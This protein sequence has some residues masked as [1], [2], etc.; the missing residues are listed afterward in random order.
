QIEAAS[1]GLT[2]TGSNSPASIDDTRRPDGTFYDHDDPSGDY[3]VVPAANGNNT[4]RDW[5]FRLDPNNVLGYYGHPNPLRGEFVLNR[6]PVDVNKYPNSVVADKN[7]RGA[8]FDFEFNKSPNGVI[9]Y[10][11]NAEGGNLQGAMIVCRY[12]GGSDLIALVPDGPNGDITTSKVGIPGFTGFDDPLDLVEDVTTGNIYVSDYG[13][14]TIVLLRPSNQASPS[15]IISLNP[16]SVITEDVV[17]GGAGDDV[18]I[19]VTNSGNAPL[20]NPTVSISGPDAAS[21]SFDATNLPTSLAA[22]S[23]ASITVNFTAASEGAKTATLTVSGDDADPATVALNGLGKDGT[24]GGN[25]PSLQFIFDTYGLAIDVGDQ[26]PATNLINLPNGATYNDLLGDEVDIQEFERAIDAPVTIEVLAVYGPEA[27]NPIVG[28]GWYESGDAS[29]TNEVFTVQNNVTGNGQTLNPVVTGSLSFDPGLTSFGFYNRWPFFGNRFLYSEDALNTFNNSIPHHVRVYELPGEEN[30]YVIATEEHTSGF[31]Y[32]DIVVIVRNIQPASDEPPVADAIQINFSNEATPAPVDYSKDFGEAYGNRGTYDFGW[33]IPGTNTPLSIVGNGRNR[34]PTP[35]VDVL[36]ETLMH[37][38]Y[39]DV[40][41]NNGVQEEGAWEIGLPNGDYEVTVAVGDASGESFGGTNHVINAEGTNILSEVA[42]Q[43]VSNFFTAT[44]IVTVNDGRL[45]LDA[46]GGVN[47]K[48]LYVNITPTSVQPMT[49]LRINAGGTAAYTD[50]NGDVWELD[51]DLLTG[52]S[53]VSSKTFDVGGTDEDDLFLEYRF[54]EN[55]AGAGEDFGY[56]IPLEA[57]QPVTVKLYFI[58][59]FFGV[60]GT[61]GAGQGGT[62]NR[63]FDVAI[64]GQTVLTDFDLNAETPN[65]GTLVVETFENINVTDGSLTID[66]TSDINNA[67]ISAIEV[68]G[69]DDNT[70]NPVAFFSDVSPADGATGVVPTGFQITVAVNTSDGYELDKNSLAGNVKLFEQT[71]SGLV[72][73]PSNA[74]D[75]GGGDAITLTPNSLLDPLTTYVFQ[76]EGVEANVIGDLN[77]R[78]TFTTFTS[79]FTTQSEDDTNPPADL[80]GVEFTPVTGNDLGQ[81]VLGERF[82]SMAIGPDGKLYASTTGEVIKRWDIEPDG[83]LTNL[84][85]LTVNL[86]GSNHPVTGTPAPNNRLIIGFAFAP[87][88]TADNLIAYVTHSAATFSNGPEWDGKLTKLSGPNLA[89]VEDVLIHLPRSTKDHLTN[90]VVFDPSGDLFIIQGSNSAGGEPDASWGFR[91]ERLLAAAMLR[92]ELNKL[93]NSLPLSVFTTDDISVINTAPS[94][95]IT[96]SNGTYNPYASNSPLT[97][98]ATGIRNAYDMVFHSNGWAY[99]PTNGTAG[100]NNTSPNT[101]A[102]A[103]YVNQDPS[104]AG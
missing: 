50:G 17:G 64:E 84:E 19:F 9:E 31:D 57:T 82:S 79:S 13:Q 59:P 65:P 95:S 14:S 8:A 98:Y 104:G 29:A 43:G 46:V 68:I 102:S 55:A 85:E 66:F 51:T 49:A 93:P 33:V 3:P 52:S 101:P 36:T 26:N 27:N 47:S 15:A 92:L 38:Q 72:E 23:T 80:T 100:N 7:Y 90:S 45:T 11:S 97:L 30:A 77:D 28:F 16:E 5:L 62:G 94:N 89:T 42:V 67:I 18:T 41:G 53:E 99:V 40:A 81:G 83:T 12:S 4:Q 25:E 44:Q 32:Q 69:L 88:A 35:D 2:V 6:G 10:R 22:N 60:A 48:I 34:T 63:Q 87:E 24:G 56:E 74:N 58:E 70:G 86:E 76:I 37:M 20:E 39:D 61:N 71:G 96:M 75:T 21:F 103:A 54:A 78:I 1:M 73:V 91:P